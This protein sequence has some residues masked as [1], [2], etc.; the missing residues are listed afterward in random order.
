MHAHYSHP[1]KLQSAPSIFILRAVRST[2]IYLLFIVS[3]FRERL[4]HV[5]CPRHGACPPRPSFLFSFSF[6]VLELS[7][8]VPIVNTLAFLFTV[9]GEWWV[10][11]KVISRGT[12][13]MSGVVS[14]PVSCIQPFR[15]TRQSRHLH[16]HG[17]IAVRHRP[18]CA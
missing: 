9:I 3:L 14:S 17:P 16:R 10:E 2:L 1:F 12:F 6:S 8:T 7:L 4:T 5:F 13:R 11:S 18:V 15:L